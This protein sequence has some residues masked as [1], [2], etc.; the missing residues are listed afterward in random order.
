MASGTIM[1]SAALSA[2]GCSRGAEDAE[3]PGSDPDELGA[4]DRPTVQE[5]EDAR[6]VVEDVEPRA[7]LDDGGDRDHGSSDDE[8]LGEV[9][10]VL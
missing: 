6:E 3:P 2:I 4:A 5:G 1:T 8:R 9:V 7:R 10:D